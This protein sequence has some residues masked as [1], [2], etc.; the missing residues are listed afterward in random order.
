MT[1][2]CP[3]HEVFSKEYER[4]K[5]NEAE[6]IEQ[7]ANIKNPDNFFQ[8][9]PFSKSKNK[10]YSVTDKEYKEE[11]KMARMKKSIEKS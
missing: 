5:H 8:G 4:P 10:Q 1:Y 9:L 3:E 11:M 7:H 2:L 6:Y